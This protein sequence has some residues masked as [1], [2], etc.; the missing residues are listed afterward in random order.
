MVKPTPLFDDLAKQMAL[1]DPLAAASKALEP[2][3]NVSLGGDAL[4]AYRRQQEA[5]KLDPK[6]IDRALGVNEDTLKKIKLLADQNK[7]YRSPV[8]E[9][10]EALK[11]PLFPASGSLPAAPVVAALPAL[12]PLM[13]VQSVADIGK[14]VR[15]ARRKMGMTQQRFA[16]LAG[17][18]RRFLLELER[19]KATLEIGRVLAVC[20]AAGIKLRIEP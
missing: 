20:R 15:E 7:A 4:L 5:L 12:D 1:S 9:A 16:D 3:Y 8:Q 17:V 6:L 14:R 13:V 19:G 10:I 11:Q 2:L 18:G